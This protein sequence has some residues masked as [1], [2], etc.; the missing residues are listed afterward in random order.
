M[1]AGIEFLKQQ[2][3]IYFR[4]AWIHR[5]IGW[6]CGWG[7]SA[8]AAF[9]GI[10]L[11]THPDDHTV[12]LWSALIAAA[13]TAVVQVVKPE[14]WANAYYKGHIVLEQVLGDY[15]LGKATSDDLQQARHTA[16]QG[17]PGAVSGTVQNG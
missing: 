17:L 1:R 13:L 15:V 9:G 3:H 8:L 16:Q 12:P 2:E 14:L 6:I 10:W 7:G 5:W 11:S 4:Q